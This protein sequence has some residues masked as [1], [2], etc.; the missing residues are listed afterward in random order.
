VGR[1]RRDREGVDDDPL[2]RGLLL[3]QAA[4][5]VLRAR[6]LPERMAPR[7]LS[8]RVHRGRDLE[9][10]G[11]LPDVRLRVRGEADGARGAPARR[12]RER[13]R[14]HGEGAGRAHGAHAAE[15]A[16]RGVARGAPRRTEAERAVRLV[17]GPPG[18]HQ[19]AAV[20]PRAPREIGIP[21]LRGGRALAPRAPVGALSGRPGPPLAD[22]R[23]LRPRTRGPRRQR[24]TTT[25]LRCSATKW[26]RSASS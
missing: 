20:R 9:P 24:P 23:P 12:E 11:L 13:A 3:L 14:V 1:R 4:Q 18:A 8:G 19:A 22:A 21:R 10:G 25:A 17:R 5:R 2:L 26:R 7:A 16:P 6:V 15:G